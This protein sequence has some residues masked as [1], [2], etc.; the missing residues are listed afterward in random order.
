MAHGDLMR[1]AEW[2]SVKWHI[3]L[4]QFD[5]VMRQ[6]SGIG[7]SVGRTACVFGDGARVAQSLVSYLGCSIV[8][9]LVLVIV[10]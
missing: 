1:R 10:S 5:E 2:R 8:A 4:R 3:A 9:L 7:S 6:V